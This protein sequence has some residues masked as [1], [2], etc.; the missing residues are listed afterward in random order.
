VNVTTNGSGQIV[1]TTTPAVQAAPGG[2]P[3]ADAACVPLNLLGYGL[4]DPAA[5]AYVIAQNVTRSVLDQAVFNANFGGSPFDLFGNGVGFNIGYEHRLEKGAF[6]PSAFQQAGL[7]RSV[8]IAPTSGK[9]NV[10]EVFGE[11]KVPLITESN[12]ISFINRL[13]LD[14]SGRYV[15]NTVNGGFFAWSAGGTFS[16]VQDLTFRGTY[17]KS[18][19]A[20]A[21][22]ELFLPISNAFST[23]PDLCSAANING[24]AAPAIRKANCT[25]FL[26]KYPNATPLDAATATVPSQSGGNPNLANEISRSFSY[27]IIIQPRWIPGLSISADYIDIRIANPISNLT[28][29]TIASGCFDNPNF[30]AADP[31]NGNAFCSQIRRYASGQGGT[32]VN[33]G[34]RG[35]QVVNDPLNPGVRSGFVNGNRI[36]FSGIQ[37]S[38]NYNTSLSGLGIPGRFEIGSDFLYVRRRLVDITGV[39]PLRTD[40]TFTDPKFAGQIN[41]RY[42]NEDFG[43]TSSINIVGKQIFTRAAKNTDLREFN[44]IDAYATVNGSIYFKV[45]KRF[46]L[47]L[48]VTNVFNRVG[49]LY[50]GA[51]PLALTNDLQGRRFAA[52]V[53]TKF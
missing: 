27:G 26:A 39:A 52:S 17:T 41:L 20:P 33:G 3:V 21:I 34:D 1:C 42:A 24:G 32:A 2:T 45:D 38:L 49:Q 31:A 37:G 53:N 44:T 8:A 22:T 23:V 40:G 46:R 47:T 4:S 12:G 43:I 13:E 30:N 25:A 9:Y 7:G 6:I 10:D 36:F 28:V 16:P 5:R 51:Y 29:A 18:F 14:A 11:V 19:R 50:F 15:D 48:S 35:G